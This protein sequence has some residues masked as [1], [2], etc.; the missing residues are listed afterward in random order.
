MTAIQE[1]LQ[2]SQ[3]LL[4]A[5]KSSYSTSGYYTEDY[6]ATEVYSWLHADTKRDLNTT[7][8]PMGTIIY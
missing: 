3:S 5:A 7:G 4:F 2:E 8:N 1:Y 6:H